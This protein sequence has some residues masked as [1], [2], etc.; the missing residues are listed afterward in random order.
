M[1]PSTCSSSTIPSATTGS[2]SPP[3]TTLAQELIASACDQRIFMVWISRT[4]ALYTDTTGSNHQLSTVS[5][6]V[7]WL[8][9]ATN[10][11]TIHSH[12]DAI[13]LQLAAR[14]N[15]SVL[16]SPLDTINWT[17]DNSIPA[18][19]TLHLLAQLSS[20]NPPEIMA[21]TARVSANLLAA[22]ILNGTHTPTPPTSPSPTPP[23]SS[24]LQQ[25]AK[26]P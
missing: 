1:M 14:S 16:G 11:A 6:L 21:D 25:L 15:T 19:H 23:P 5:L 9:N 12:E 4:Q 13:K 8:F 2:T 22:G 24:P 17:I 20:C 3:A 26:P 18:A 7:R 10:L